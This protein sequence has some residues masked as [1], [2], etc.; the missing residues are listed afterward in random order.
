MTPGEFKLFP[1]YRRS[2]ELLN[3]AASRLAW[4]QRDLTG[5]C[6][7]EA[8]ARQRGPADESKWVRHNQ[9]STRSFQREFYDAFT[10][11]QSC[12]LLF[13]RR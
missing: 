12:F 8:H 4:T 5:K 2:L 3:E 9:E 1:E 7:K 13:K 11:A 10:P 6:G